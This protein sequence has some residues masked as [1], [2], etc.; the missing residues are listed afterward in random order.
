MSS[1]RLLLVV[2]LVSCG[3]N[4]KTV[5]LLPLTSPT[6][7]IAASTSI[8]GP[9]ITV[10]IQREWDL[11]ISSWDDNYPISAIE[12]VG[13]SIVGVLARPEEDLCVADSVAD[14]EIR[15]FVWQRDAFVL[16]GTIDDV[17]TSYPESLVQFIDMTA[18]GYPE[19]VIETSECA[20]GWVR[21]F[22]VGEQGIFEMVSGSYLGGPDGRTLMVWEESCEPTC[23]DGAGSEFEL[24]WN[25]QTFERILI[26]K[27]LPDV[28]GRD[29]SGLDMTGWDM[30]G[31]DLTGADLN[32][33]ILDNANLKGAVLVGAIL[34]SASL[35]GADLTGANLRDA[36]FADADLSYANLERA[37]LRGAALLYTDL[38]WA[39]L[40]QADV[41]GQTFLNVYLFGATMPDGF[42]VTREDE[43]WTD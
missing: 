25:G 35:V 12:I 3:A 14:G 5:P 4:E 23:A 24:R 32:S 15:I 2:V 34:A 10:E 6:S 16:L 38:R 36:S 31:W 19:L 40:F 43:P 21:V 8:A 26:S 17:S 39:N 7:Q 33:S 9:S 27:I 13:S 18:E 1:L 11:L 20:N 30:E 22:S 29:L 37:D 28:A 41:S 42:R